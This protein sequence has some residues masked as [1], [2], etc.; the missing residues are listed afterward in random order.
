M[1][2]WS[3]FSVPSDFSSRR[4][5][6]RPTKQL[7]YIKTMKAALKSIDAVQSDQYAWIAKAGDTF[8]LTVE[9]DH[10]DT[11][12]NICDHFEGTF[13]KFVGPLSVSSGDEPQTVRHSQQLFDAVS[14]IHS[15]SS[16]CK[17][18]LSKGT[19]YGSSTGGVRGAVDSDLWIV[20]E[21]SGDV[22]V[23]FGFVLVRVQ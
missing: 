11:A 3:T 19:K 1:T 21:L 22:G 10:K 9:L 18:L 12:N 6:I 4:I 16:K 8:V 14:E 5:K 23:G 13:K 2:H 20:K 17:L 15:E 7:R